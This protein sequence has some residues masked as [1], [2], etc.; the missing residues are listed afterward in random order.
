[1]GEVTRI[2]AALKTVRPSPTCEEYDLHHLVA[3]ALEKAGIPYAYFDVETFD[4]YLDLLK[5]F[6]TLTGRPDLFE[7]NGTAILTQVKSSID[8]MSSVLPPNVLLLRTS[9]SNVKSLGSDTMVGNMLKDLGCRN[10]ADSNTHLL[11]DLSLEGIAKAD[12]DYIF[13]ICM[14]D[15]DEA[16][17]HF[18]FALSSNPIW[19]T[20][21]AVK[22]NRFYFLPKELFHYKPNARWGESYETLVDLLTTK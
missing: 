17:A 11:T 21:T 1:M 18:D 20:L 3:Q 10:I 14:G 8:Q 15:T 6:T 9:S 4:D 5:I 12:P 7:T 16:I 22:E 13:V 2:L 19:G